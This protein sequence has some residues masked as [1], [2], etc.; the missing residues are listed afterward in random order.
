MSVDQLRKLI[1]LIKR[2]NITPEMVERVP[3]IETI[4]LRKYDFNKN[5]SID[6][7]ADLI[8]GEM[9]ENMNRPLSLHDNFYNHGK[10]LEYKY[11]RTIVSRIEQKDS[12]RDT[13]KD[14]F[15]LNINPI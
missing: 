9:S 1:N 3:N 8:G 5:K 7:I 15:K 6:T 4:I 13:I 11:Y 14:T 2:V 12:I 10:Y